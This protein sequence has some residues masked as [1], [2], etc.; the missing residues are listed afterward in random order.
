MKED[1]EGRTGAEKLSG[2]EFAGEKPGTQEK[3][4]KADILKIL[5]NKGAAQAV[6]ALLDNADRL[7]SKNKSIILTAAGKRRGAAAAIRN[8]K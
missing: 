3:L 2:L 1:E 6:Q 4:T 8:L 7:K 5:G